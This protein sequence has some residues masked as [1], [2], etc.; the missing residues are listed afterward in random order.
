MSQTGIDALIQAQGEAKATLH[1][2]AAGAN[3]SASKNT[4][5]LI[6]TIAIL[7]IG[8]AYLIAK[9]SLMPKQSDKQKAMQLMKKAKKY[10]MNGDVEMAEK[11]I[12]QMFEMPWVRSEL[13]INFR[14]IRVITTKANGYNAVPQTIEKLSKQLL[15][16]DKIKN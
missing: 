16:N 6:A 8:F 10:E 13:Q 9:P 2:N 4:K 7:V 12:E 5:L 1:D 11:T 3:C 15:K 14:H